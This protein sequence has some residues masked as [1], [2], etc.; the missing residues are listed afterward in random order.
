MIDH[1]FIGFKT[2][3][4]SVE[5]EK[6]RLRLFAKAIG[7]L[8]PIYSDETAALAAGFRSLPVPPTFLFCLEMERPDAYDWCEELNVPLARVLHGE[9]AF[10]YYGAA[11]AGDL[12]TFSSEIVDIYDKKNGTLEFIVRKNTITNQQNEQIAEFD[13]TLV[14]RPKSELTT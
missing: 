12:L 11:Y 5:V 4:F 13:S 14:I 10:T 8:D 7:E 2:P 9:Q 3:P 6:G 1:S